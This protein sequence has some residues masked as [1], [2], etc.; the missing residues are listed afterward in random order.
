MISTKDLR[1][2]GPRRAGG[3]APILAG[4]TL[5]IEP[6]L[7]C[8]LGA[9][10]D[11]GPLLLDV[12]AGKVPPRS[13]E[14]TVLGK[15]PADVRARVAH[16]PAEVILPE[17][18]TVDEVFALG[19]KI[20]SEPA[21][22]HGDLL[23]RLG[24]AH[25]AGRRLGSL[26]QPE[27][28]SV[29]FAEAVGSDATVLLLEEPFASTSLETPARLGDILRE[30]ASAG[31]VVVVA[32]ASARTPLAFETT[33]LLSKGVPFSMNGSEPIALARE[34]KLRVIS[35]DARALAAALAA[36]DGTDAKGPGLTLGDGHLVLRGKDILM[37]S[38]ALGAAVCRSNARIVAVVP[39]LAT[40]DQLKEAAL[41]Q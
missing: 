18:L 7:T 32:T 40:T 22:Q 9:R 8:L 27:I 16:V 6:G 13:G 19:R 24:I 37:L 35:P 25:L 15:R 23:A 20:R 31:A 1:A 11:G 34:A 26:S 21:K 5:E 36:G 14:V 30:R 33:W 4:V 28:R 29:A 12:C 38:R 41:T 10:D 2:T 3:N 39:D 17:I